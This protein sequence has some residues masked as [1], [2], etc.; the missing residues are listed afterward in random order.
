MTTAFLYAGQGS[1]HPGMGKDLYEHCP[2]F[3]RVYDKIPGALKDLCLNGPADAL[4]ATEN[5]QPA[6]VAFAIGVTTLLAEAG[7]HPDYTAGLSLGEYSALYAAGVFDEKTAIDLVTY[8]GKVM[9]DASQGIDVGMAAVM[10]LDAVTLAAICTKASASG[11]VFI[12]NLNCPGQIV[13][14]GEKAGVDQACQLAKAAGARRCVPL[15]VSGPFHTPFMKSA[16]DA[17]AVRFKT[18]PFHP[19][20]IPVCFNCLGREIHGDERIPDLLERQVQSPVHMEATL[21]RLAELGVDTWVEIGPG[22]TLSGFVKKTLK[23]AHPVSLETREDIAKF[24]ALQKENR[25]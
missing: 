21:C 7:I 20:R 17:L 8:R 25:L 11:K 23:G 13:I 6:M 2:T 9:A 14:S 18:T 10:Q 16:G 5:T 1:Q 19:M 24:I 4:S 12:A 22:K 15:R 3:A